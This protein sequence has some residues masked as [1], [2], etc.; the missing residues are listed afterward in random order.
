M[1]ERIGRIFSWWTA[2]IA[3]VL[4]AAA[5]PLG[6]FARYVYFHVPFIKFHPVCYDGNAFF[7][8]NNM[9]INKGHVTREF[10]VEAAKMASLSPDI[11]ITAQ[12]KNAYLSLVSW[13]SHGYLK[14]AL[15]GS[16]DYRRR[17]RWE[18]SMSIVQEIFWR[19]VAQGVITDEIRNEYLFHDIRRENEAPRWL[20]PD[21]CG[22]LPELVIEGG[23]FAEAKRMKQSARL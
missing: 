10:V 22:L 1:R 9:K 23:R 5:V 11:E 6:W 13:I 15:A 3:A 16:V 17:Y 20:R 8:A 21:E 18:Y 12:G 14:E 4:I 19:R 2:R 7:P